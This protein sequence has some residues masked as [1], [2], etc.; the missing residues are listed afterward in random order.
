MPKPHPTAH[1]VVLQEGPTTMPTVAAT[2]RADNLPQDPACAPL[3]PSPSLLPHFGSSTQRYR[4]N[5]SSA[6][7]SDSRAPSCKHGCLG[8]GS[9]VGGDS[10]LPPPLLQP[11]H[12]PT[13]PI[14]PQQLSTVQ[15]GKSQ[16]GDR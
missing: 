11:T 5:R 8:D 15:R 1:Q 12:P 2:T 14:L 9:L 7:K 16:P 13:H 4:A 6:E 3:S 10:G